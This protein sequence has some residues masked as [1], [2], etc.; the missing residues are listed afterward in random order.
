[1]RTVSTAYSG[2]ALGPREDLRPQL[3]GQAGDEAGEQLLHRLGRERLEV[4]R[5]EVA[6]TRAPGRPP[7]EQLGPRLRDDEDRRVAGPL[8]QVL[9]EVEQRRV[10]PLHVLEDHH[11][12]VDVGQPLEEQPP[13]GEEVLALVAAALLLEPE[14]VGQ[15]RLDE[16]ALVRVGD[17]LLDDR[18]E[19]GERRARLLVL[20]DPRAHPDHVRERPVGDALAVG[21]AAAA[22]PVRDLDDPVE[23]LVELPAEPRLADP[24]DPGDRDEVRLALVGA[25][26]EELLDLAQLTVAADERRLEPGRLQRRRARRRRRAAR[27]RAASRPTFPFSSWLPASS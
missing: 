17:V 14:Q 27:A 26:V 13:G 1:M 4:D 5:G 3:V 16:A 7:L 2:I 25:G 10:R 15:P 9:D 21:E 22:V 24:G 12:R 19:L 18:G 8:E 11:H 23:V 6:M 20:D